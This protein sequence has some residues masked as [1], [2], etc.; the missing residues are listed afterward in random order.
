MHCC[1]FSWSHLLQ[2][3]FVTSSCWH[4]MVCK[5]RRRE[6]VT[7]DAVVCKPYYFLYTQP[8]LSLRQ[9]M[10]L[11]L[12]PPPPLCVGPA[13]QSLNFIIGTV[14]AYTE[15]CVCV[16]VCVLGGWMRV[17][18]KDGVPLALYCSQHTHTFTL[19]RDP[20]TNKTTKQAHKHTRGC[21]IVAR[22]HQRQQCVCV[23]YTWP[24][25][26]LNH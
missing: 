25:H 9:V 6:V 8:F 26:C 17:S 4:Q 1:S 15:V 7:S 24:Q 12:V 21:L 2:L 18:V 16:C 10:L 3:Q 20:Y 23:Y 5:C 14:G 13:L 22:L 19:M 11:C